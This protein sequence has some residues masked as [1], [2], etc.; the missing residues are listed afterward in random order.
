MVNYDIIARS[1]IS[2]ESIGEE[3]LLELDISI[4]NVNNLRS[5]ACERAPGEDGKEFGG[6]IW[7]A[8]KSGRSGSPG[9][10]L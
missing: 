4:Y 7:R 9:A 5:K 2:V 6:Q 8:K 1:E 3:C 10:C